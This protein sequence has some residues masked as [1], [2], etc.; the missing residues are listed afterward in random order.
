M[1]SHFL[2]HWSSLALPHISVPLSSFHP[3]Q[4]CLIIWGKWK[5]RWWC[6][7]GVDQ[8]F[9]R[10]RWTLFPVVQLINQCADRSRGSTFL[11]CLSPAICERS[12]C[13]HW[14]S[15]RYC[16][17]CLVNVEVMLVWMQ[18]HWWFA[19]LLADRNFAHPLFW[20]GGIWAWRVLHFVTINWRV[21]VFHFRTYVEFLLL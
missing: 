21:D 4:L 14:E 6:P 11:W 12:G 3:F 9:H 16:C 7:N 17:W 19:S 18:C 13:L 2:L 10:R 8:S 20:R 1:S 5:G 15:K